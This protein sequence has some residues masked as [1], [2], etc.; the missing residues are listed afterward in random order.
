M[1]EM[2]RLAT[3]ALLP[4]SVAFAV[5]AIRLARLG[6]YYNSSAQIFV[7]FHCR[8]TFD[9]ASGLESH[10]S[11]CWPPAAAARSTL[12]TPQQQQQQ[13]GGS[14][15]D[16]SR[17][18]GHQN[19]N[20]CFA[21]TT[22]EVTNRNNCSSGDRDRTPIFGYSQFYRETRGGNI[23]AN[24]TGEQSGTPDAVGLCNSAN[25][26]PTWR[27]QPDFECLKD[28]AVR[29]STFYDWPETA[30][31]IVKPCD[32]A[33]AGMFYTGQTDRVQC[34]F[35]RGC[36]RNWV[37]GDNPA[38]E[39]RKHFPDCSFI[40]QLKGETTPGTGTSSHGNSYRHPELHESSRTLSSDK[41]HDEF[42]QSS[43]VCMQYRIRHVIAS[44]LKISQ[45]F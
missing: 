6:F 19:P 9:D 5:N 30:A 24:V 13:Q 23:K 3:F 43:Q 4:L 27:H 28:E 25:T 18:N 16:V 20:F 21:A 22:S 34:A 10:T 41:S 11:L 37:Q 8:Q 17:P 40:R 33:K 39:H 44:L 35:C 12:T 2:T 38:E 42:Q 31:R 45:N 36:L 26:S 7:C 15:H 14:E 1:D 29:L 32:L